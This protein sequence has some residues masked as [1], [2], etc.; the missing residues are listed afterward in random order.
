[1]I[2][3]YPGHE[4]EAFP[5][6]M[7]I[8]I[9]F[10]SK[11]KEA[12]R[13]RRAQ[14]AIQKHREMCVSHAELEEDD[15]MHVGPGSVV[16]IMAKCKGDKIGKHMLVVFAVD[17]CTNSKGPVYAIAIAAAD[18]ASKCHFVDGRVML[19][20]AEGR[21]HIVWKSGSFTSAVLKKVPVY[22]VKVLNPE[23][24]AR[25]E[26]VCSEDASSEGLAGVCYRFEVKQL[27]ELARSYEISEIYHA[28]HAIGSAGKL[29]YMNEAGDEI[30]VRE[31]QTRK[32]VG[33][34]TVPELRQ[35]L[36]NLQLPKSGLKA[37]LQTRLMGTGWP[38][39]C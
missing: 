30:G 2:R 17:S 6:E 10:G 3:N 37:E 22:Y 12:G 18:S 34:M 7:A 25:H 31:V 8:K 9:E 27:N 29:P 11:A 5:I 16:A 4:G 15:G 14:S 1:M 24:S 38:D 21:D 26:Q 19:L 13:L 33:D 39:V 28:L 23:A 35:A 36:E 32:P 20:N